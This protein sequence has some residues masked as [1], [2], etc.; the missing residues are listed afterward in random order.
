MVFHQ[1]NIKDKLI[2]ENNEII[3]DYVLTIVYN[4]NMKKKVKVFIAILCVMV[5]IGAFFG[6]VN[7]L[8]L[9]VVRGINNYLMKDRTFISAHRGGA[10]L[11][12]ENTEKAFDYVIKETTF[13]DFVEIDVHATKDDVL[14]INHDE[15]I[16][17]TSLPANETYTV[18]IK[19]T[20]YADLL[21]YNVGKNFVSKD[22]SMPYYNLS[23]EEAKEEKLT[24]MK[25]EDFLIKYNN[26]R[27]FKLLLEIKAKDDEAIRIAKLIL[28]MYQKEEHEWW[29]DQTIIISF[30][31]E[32]LT[33]FEN[34]A[35]YMDTS[36]LGGDA[37]ALPILCKFALERLVQIDKKIVQIMAKPA[38]GFL[39]VNLA[40][41]RLIDY[42]H[43]RNQA[44][45]FWT[46]NDEKQ[47]EDLISIG[48][49]IITTDDPLMLY[50]VMQN[51][52]GV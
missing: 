18:N 14:V 42:S 5:T 9:K 3:S 13:S 43:K 24:I 1:E 29:R 8:P 33:F 28:N 23:I 6:I 4:K 35:P 15:S 30:S 34:N 51:K 41:K 52:K 49:D 36:P 25:F 2:I 27:D 31:N 16:N 50:K 48:A 10:Y 44:L 47:M 37:L 22:G 39:S 20:D 21:K 46:V 11:N 38:Y 45:A 26:V 17:R 12:P 19:D 7:H 40:T 32:V